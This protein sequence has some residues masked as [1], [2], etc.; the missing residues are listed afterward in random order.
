MIRFDNVSKHFTGHMSALSDVTVE[1]KDGEFVFLIGPSGQEKLLFLIRD[2][3]DK[4]IHVDQW[5]FTLIP[6]VYLLAKYRNG[7]SF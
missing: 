1:I 6:R 2:T 5:N 4:G 3:S 7:I